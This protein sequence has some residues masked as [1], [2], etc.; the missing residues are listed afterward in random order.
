[1]E[2]KIT[3]VYIAGYVTR[4]EDHSPQDTFIYYEKYGHFL[5]D[6]NRFLVRLLE[7]AMTL[8]HHYPCFTDLKIEYVVLPVIVFTCKNNSKILKLF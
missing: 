4:H 5:S 7:Y 8:T 1:M 3:L 6:M 2:T